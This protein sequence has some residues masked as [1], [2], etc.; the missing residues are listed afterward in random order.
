MFF[1]GLKKTHPIR[2]TIVRSIYKTQVFFAKDISKFAL[3]GHINVISFEFQ[4]IFLNFP[5][6]SAEKLYLNF[7]VKG[8]RVNF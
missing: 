1:F 5:K 7:C 6:I 4:A 3:P 8:Y 2:Y